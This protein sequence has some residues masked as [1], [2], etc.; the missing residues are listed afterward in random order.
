MKSGV[1]ASFDRLCFTSEK[2]GCGMGNTSE[3]QVDDGRDEREGDGEFVRESDP[4]DDVDDE[5]EW[6]NNDRPRLDNLVE[7]LE[8][9]RPIGKR[10][11]GMSEDSRR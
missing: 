8:F 6:E 9:E 5:S 11:I 10:V 4:D 7:Q 2:L 3:L 1:G